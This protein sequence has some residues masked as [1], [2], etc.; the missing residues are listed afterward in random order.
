MYIQSF[1]YNMNV[2]IYFLGQRIQLIYLIL[3]FGPI[4]REDACAQLT[5]VPST[6]WAENPLRCDALIEA[7]SGKYVILLESAAY[8]YSM[9]TTVQ[10]IFALIPILIKN[11]LQVQPPSLLVREDRQ[12]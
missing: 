8:F 10:F 5:G 6:H 3:K 9:F 12:G 2:F 7:E 11:A 4:A 1:L